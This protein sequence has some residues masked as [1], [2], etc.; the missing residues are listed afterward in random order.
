M[1]EIG[2][3]LKMLPRL[4]S[5]IDRVMG[6]VPM[7]KLTKS[8]IIRSTIKQTIRDNFVCYTKFRREIVVVLDS[9]LQMS[10]ENCITVFSIYK[11]VVVQTIQLSQFYDWCKSK[12]FCGFYEYPLVD[13]IPI[14]QIQILKTFLKGVWEL[15]KSSS[16]MSSLATTP[17]I[18]AVIEEEEI[19][20]T[21]L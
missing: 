1:K 12:G 10:Y 17:S 8:S 2:D 4:Q 18:K 15:T 9:L 21:H 5:T 20:A 13:R 14:I 16:P 3:M 7:E 19:L 11:K 6:C